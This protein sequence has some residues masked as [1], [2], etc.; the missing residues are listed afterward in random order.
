MKQ[1][2]KSPHFFGVRHL[3]P[4]GAYQLLEFLNE[5]RP[6]AVLVEGLSDA[7]PQI[8]YFAGKATKPPVAI[9][10][11]TE[12]LPVR[13]LLYP[14][15]Q[16]SPEYQAFV[17]AKK[18]NAHAEFIDLPSDVFISLEYNSKYGDEADGA[19]K[20]DADETSESGEDDPNIKD[21]SN[22]NEKKADNGY[23]VISSNTGENKSVY[24]KWALKAGEDDHDTY[25]ER[26]FEHNLNKDAYRLAVFEFG[27]SI[28]ELSRDNKSEMAKNLV[29]EAYMRK[30]IQDVINYGHQPEKIVVVTGAYH[31]PALGGDLPPMTEEEFLSLP[32]VKTKLT[33]MPYSYYRLSSRSGYGAGNNA[34]A[35][36][37]MMWK[38]LRAGDFEKLPSEYF[39]S[40]VSYL[41]GSGT[42]RSA[43]E[44]IEAVRLSNTLAAMHG[45]SAPTLRDLRD[46]AVVSFGYG[47]L[48]V[49]AEAMAQVEVGTAIGSLPEGVSRTS[50]QDDFYRELRR[51]K[52]EK[53]KSSV[54]MDLDLDLRENRRVKSEE[55]AFLDLNRSCFLHRLK[56]LNISFQKYKPKSQETAT[57]AEAWVLKWTPEAEIEL[58]ESVLRGE[59][60]ELA[61]AFV[62]KER[63]EKCEKI[64][65]AALVIRQACECGMM[66]SM[67][68][69]REVLQRLA[70]D[71]GAFNEAAFAAFQLSQV[72]SYGDIRKFD[73]SK[74]VP[75]LEQL[76]LRSTLLMLDASNCDNTAAAQV[77]D[78]I[79][80][81]NT[82]ALEYYE[83]VDE[84]LW[85][86]KLVELS[87]RDDRN[88]KLS[89]FACSIL[90]ER[91][92]IDSEKLS[93]EV[94]RRLSPGIEADLGAGWFEGL[95]MRNRYALLAR[96]GLWKQISQYVAQLDKE[97]F[98]RALVFLRRAFADFNTSEKRSICEKLGETWGVDSEDA[99]DLLNRE[100]SSEEQQSISELNDFDFGDI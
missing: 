70:V 50:I 77:A 32:S 64:G 3:S 95:S 18:N 27:K 84:E 75:L 41:R 16:Y 15:A 35:Y 51:L 99:S 36:Y 4:Q 62:F 72:I 33:L 74:L 14:F 82:I 21:D 59:T 10:A 58:V 25:W 94:S 93:Q 24:D 61:V 43:A 71:T 46:A 11:Y 2:G 8:E 91:N 6:T 86:R 78:S 42:H 40:M 69:A 83:T 39:S 100:L 97:Q 54:A 12:E 56:A 49:V 30:K 80:I 67:E 66:E 13:T 73:S 22:I 1:T 68:Q 57:W 65:E 34:P 48:T 47:E 63:L 96:T 7:N 9:L 17:W 23:K 45:G 44:V 55:A 52:L 28:R 98:K 20:S 37:E 85:I 89:G 53:Y 38:C 76:F 60:V 87:E 19:V 29:R 88:P 5:I 90:L 81:L 92:L 79:N 26:N 31:S